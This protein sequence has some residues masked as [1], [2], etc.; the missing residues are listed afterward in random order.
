LRHR[1]HCQLRGPQPLF[2][3]RRPPLRLSLQCLPRRSSRRHP[4]Q[5]QCRLPLRLH[6]RL[7]LR[8]RLH[9]AR[10]RAAVV[11]A[12]PTSR[13]CHQGCEYL[14]AVQATGRITATPCS[15]ASSPR[16]A[17]PSAASSPVFGEPREAPTPSAT[18]PAATKLRAA[19]FPPAGSARSCRRPSL[20]HTGNL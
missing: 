20:Q 5:Q 11:L 17:A 1:W 4:F 13:R 7:H 3:R 16:F 2:P 18:F 9:D 10:P 6:L 15:T 19:S 8:P 14:P 12:I